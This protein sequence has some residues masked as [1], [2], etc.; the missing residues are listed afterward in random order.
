MNAMLWPLLYLSFIYDCRHSSQQHMLDWRMGMVWAELYT[1][2]EMSNK[3]PSPA[4]TRQ[5]TPERSFNLICLKHA[6]A[7]TYAHT[8]THTHTH[9][10][11]QTPDN[12]I[13]MPLFS[14]STAL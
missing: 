4:S 14:T 10:L 1:H 3:Q 7:H 8:H 13:K 6:H 12:I 5:A 11:G 9:Q 2:R